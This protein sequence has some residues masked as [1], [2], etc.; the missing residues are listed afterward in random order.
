MA[1]ATE[2]DV[3]NISKIDKQL[4][5]YSDVNEKKLNII[6]KTDFQCTHVNENDTAKIKSNLN[7]KSMY[8]DVFSFMLLITLPHAIPI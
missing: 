6:P 2:S 5:T 4:P 8:H 7:L 3:I 1:L